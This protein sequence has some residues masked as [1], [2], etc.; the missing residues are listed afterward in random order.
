[1]TGLAFGNGWAS[2]LSQRR[3]CFGQ[4]VKSSS[5][6]LRAFSSLGTPVQGSWLLPSAASP[7]GETGVASRIQRL[8]NLIQFLLT[9]GNGMSEEAGL[10]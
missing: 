3:V 5:R 8:S 4:W 7:A 10:G 2:L 1:M 6:R 9:Q